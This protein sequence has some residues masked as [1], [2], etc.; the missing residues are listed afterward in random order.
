[1]QA[2]VKEMRM[3]N[4]DEHA[5]EAQV[6]IALLERE[7]RTL[8]HRIP[9]ST[10]RRWV[11]VQPVLAR[12]SGV[13][14]LVRFLQ[15]EQPTAGEAR[16]KDELL[17]AL[18]ALARDDLLAGRVVLQALLPG[19]KQ[20]AGRALFDA[21]ERELFWELLLA[22]TWSRVRGY[23]LERRRRSVAANLLFDSLQRTLRELGRERRHRRYTGFEPVQNQPLRELGEPEL[24]LREAVRARAITALEAQLIFV[25]RLERRPLTD[26]AAQEGLAYN[27]A[28]VRLQRAER[29][30]LIFFGVRPVPKRRPN[31]PSSSARASGAGTAD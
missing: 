28:R 27:V 6:P 18:L 13:A 26:A 16:A 15:D 21:R 17:C 30:L 20:L 9:A 12:F 25:V 2:D 8:R 5:F 7:W 23:P 19:L 3:N 31:A 29:R 1:L 22:H 24:V 4:F 10:Y 11:S 14:A